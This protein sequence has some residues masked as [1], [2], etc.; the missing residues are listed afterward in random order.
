MRIIKA[1]L[2]NRKKERSKSQFGVENVQKFRK[3]IF[4]L[5]RMWISQLVRRAGSGV[6][7]LCARRC[8]DCPWRGGMKI[9]RILSTLTSFAVL[10]KPCRYV[11]CTHEYLCYFRIACH[12]QESDRPTVHAKQLVNDD[13]TE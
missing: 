5:N 4:A 10:Q 7:S 11:G 8:S 3:I 1:M 6:K 13:L 2:A 12:E 9:I